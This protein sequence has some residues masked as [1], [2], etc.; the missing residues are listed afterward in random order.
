MGYAIKW[1]DTEKCGRGG[2]GRHVGFRF[3][4]ATVQ[5]QV[6]LP[7]PKNKREHTLPLILCKKQGMNNLNAARMRAAR[8]GST[9]RILYFLPQAENATKSLSPASNKADLF[10]TKSIWVVGLFIV[11]YCIITQ[12]WYYLFDGQFSLYRWLIPPHSTIRSCSL[13]PWLSILKPKGGS[14]WIK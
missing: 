12:P 11:E 7:V 1:I 13:F 6:L 3:Q 2:I 5:V 4:W 10:D 9:E 14:L 8:E